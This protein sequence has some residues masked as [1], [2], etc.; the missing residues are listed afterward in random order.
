ME[1]YIKKMTE[2]VK[3]HYE[4]THTPVYPNDV[5]LNSFQ[6]VNGDVHATFH[7]GVVDMEMCLYE[8]VYF[9]NFDEFRVFCL[10]L[11][12]NLIRMIK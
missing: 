9:L 8:V 5:R 3:K 7:V 12:N 6:F 4:S 11:L 1:T 2:I 10:N